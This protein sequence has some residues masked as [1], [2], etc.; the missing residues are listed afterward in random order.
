MTTHAAP[1]RFARQRVQGAVIGG[2]FGSVFLLA[3]ARTP[4]GGIAADLFRA[5]AVL[6]FVALMIGRRR[7]LSRPSRP[8]AKASRE[9]V[10]LFGRRWRLIVV[11]EAAALAAGYVVIWLAGAPNETYLPWTVF[12]VGLHFIAFLLAGIWR[13]RIA[14]TAAVLTALGIAGLALAA[15]PATDWIPFVSGVLAGIA[16]LAGS[17]STMRRALK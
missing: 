3:N 4:L 2:T 13:G 17:L 5:L 7:V 8:R 10:D 9:R 1:D 14:Q 15:S 11:G 16:L 12:V 6:G